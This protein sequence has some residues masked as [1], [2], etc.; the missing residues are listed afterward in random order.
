[1]Q[2]DATF[3]QRQNSCS[4]TYD[5]P[6]ITAAPTLP[7]L[8]PLELIIS[9]PSG[10]LVYHF[11]YPKKT[12][13]D[14]SALSLSAAL[15]A[16]QATTKEKISLIT[17]PQGIVLS[18]VIDIFHIHVCSQDRRTPSHFLHTLS[19]AAVIAAM[20]ALSGA[21]SPHVRTNP[22]F[23][24][25]SL[26]SS[27]DPIINVTL[28]DALTYP[29]PYALHAPVSL[30]A[31]FAPRA[32]LGRVLHRAYAK[33]PNVEHALVLT[34]SP[35]F[36]HRVVA[37]ISSSNYPL[38]DSDLL[39]INACAPRRADDIPLIRRLYLQSHTYRR[40]FYTC[41]RAVQLRLDPDDYEDFKRQVGRTWTPEWTSAGGDVVWVVALATD[42]SDCEKF[43]NM[44]DGDLDRH[45]A[46][47]DLMVS[48]ERPW[49]LTEIS[50]AARIVENDSQ[51]LK[52]VV[53]IDRH[54][55]AGSVGAFEHNIGIVMVSALILWDQ[56]SNLDSLNIHREGK[57]MVVTQNG[58][59]IVVVER[60][61]LLCFDAQME[62]ERSLKISKEQLTSY[63]N[64][65]ISQLIPHDEKCAV[66]PLTP[67]A[68]F[69]IPF[70]S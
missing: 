39:L 7:D 43:L 18:T 19:R 68:N 21:F 12:R 35:P 20:T 3:W 34:A 8:P 64:R 23:D 47:K 48:M 67:L 66:E 37:S 41:F 2:P 33:C 30:P 27:L 65:I 51:F 11:S 4:P 56:D 28:K 55:V 62:K 49:T 9:A 32:S 24:P 46:A 53:V 69:L 14:A 44:V 52:A 5:L 54:R 50:D 70:R 26:R 60:R 36:P 16:Y 25:A 59:H 29:L 61:F 42:T 45:P 15:V 38:R 1:M 13:V 57:I 58:F 6:H 10:K 17:I 31:L 22:S 63:L 40:G